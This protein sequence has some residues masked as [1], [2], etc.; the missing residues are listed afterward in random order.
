M[1]IDTKQ[2]HQ[3]EDSKRK[4]RRDFPIPLPANCYVLNDV[5]VVV[6]SSLFLKIKSADQNPTAMYRPEATPDHTIPYFIKTKLK[7]K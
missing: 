4:T 1:A 6:D 7:A 5:E 2:N 3:L